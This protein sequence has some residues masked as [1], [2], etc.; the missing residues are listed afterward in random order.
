MTILLAKTNETVKIKLIPD[1]DAC[2]QQYNPLSPFIYERK[3]RKES[4][5]F[6]VRNVLFFWVSMAEGMA[7]RLDR[8]FAVAAG[9]NSH[10]D[11]FL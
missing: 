4:S 3:I 7:V 8:S 1:F 9:L 6:P 2:E 10:R 11:R 5:E